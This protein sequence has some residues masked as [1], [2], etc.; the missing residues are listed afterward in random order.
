MAGA[1]MR[2]LGVAVLGEGEE[3]AVERLALLDDL[4]LVLLRNPTV[5][6]P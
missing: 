3:K 2:Y 5:G 1:R 4:R 6:H